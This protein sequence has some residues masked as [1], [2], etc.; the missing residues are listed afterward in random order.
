MKKSAGLTLLVLSIYAFAW[1][2]KP[3]EVQVTST[4]KIASEPLA[5]SSTTA[6]APKELSRQKTPI[7]YYQESTVFRKKS[8]IQPNTNLGLESYFFPGN[9][10]EREKFYN[11]LN[12]G[13]F[14]SLSSKPKA[15]TPEEQLLGTIGAIASYGCAAGA[16]AQVLGI[17]PDGKPKDEK[18][19]K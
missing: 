2:E 16:A 13:L 1:A 18:K 12:A 9:H 11:Q 7:P 19:K 3:A 17:I 10:E 4:P 6:T 8:N 15:L 14:S 5:P